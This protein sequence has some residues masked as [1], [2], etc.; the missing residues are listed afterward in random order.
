MSILDN[1]GDN[2]DKQH[3]NHNFLPQKI[4]LEDIDLGVKNFF[5]GRNITM[6]DQTGRQRLVPVI[7]LNQELFAQR[8]NYWE[9][10]VN[11]N[12]EEIK[13][14]F[15]A[16]GRKG[17]KQGTA[18]NKRTIP[19]MKKFGFTR[20]RTFD[21][22]LMGYD[23]Y[24]VRQ[25]TWVDCDYEIR[26][27][28][29]Y[30]VDVNVFYQELLRDGFS[31]GQGY[32]SINGHQIRSVLGGPTEQNQASNID[33]ERV[34]QI[35]APL[36]VHGKLFDPADHEKKT[37]INKVV[38]K[39]C[40]DGSENQ[41]VTKTFGG[42]S[43][44]KPFRNSCDPVNIYTHNNFLLSSVGAGQSYIVS[45]STVLSASGGTL[46]ILAP[47]ELY[48]VPAGE[49]VDAVVSNSDDSFVA[50][51]GSGG[52][53]E[54]ADVDIY[55]DGG[56]V[57]S[58]PYSGTMNAVFNCASADVTITNTN[59]GLLADVGVPSGDDYEFEVPDS[60][61]EIR[62]SDE[63][64][65]TG[66]TV[67]ATENPTYVIPDI[68]VTNEGGESAVFSYSG[69]VSTNFSGAT[70]T[71]EIYYQRPLQVTQTV[72]YADGDSQW[73]LENGSYAYTGATGSTFTI[74]QLDYAATES[75][76]RG[77]YYGS[78]GDG[79]DPIAPT[80]LVG[81]NAFGNKYRF[82]DSIGN[83]SDG[84]DNNEWRHVDFKGHSFTGAENNYIIDHITGLGYYI[85]EIADGAVLHMKSNLSTGQS[86][87]DWMDFLHNDMGTIAGFDDF[88][89]LTLAEGE[90]TF[91]GA[92]AL[93]SLDWASRF[94][95]T[96]VSPLEDLY[97]FCSDSTSS[98]V[99][100]GFRQPSTLGKNVSFVK[101]YTGNHPAYP[102]VRIYVVRN[103]Y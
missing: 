74:P 34:F 93:G 30:M 33:D 65:L 60:T 39:M 101:T 86:W 78:D 24:L 84:T 3:E 12:G 18:P 61:V 81:N 35:T 26:L 38:V 48:T 88:R 82:T 21:G 4:E 57:D 103:H 62:N 79:S 27:V 11:E 68:T 37:T 14:P 20:P 17:I 1:I 64:L 77:T 44:A 56:L 97:I 29:S 58:L 19:W 67:P 42:Q 55:V 98:T 71:S 80:M 63:F 47:G 49:F 5:E 23:K 73:H 7:W 53:L 40:E 52:V 96:T 9:G 72:S 94:V 41:G 45:A 13:R 8:K 25:A 36:V 54:L 6:M 83:P 16:I 76:I 2:L 99:S 43:S 69:N 95:K 70:P 59:K 32:M 15:I 102:D 92:N 28:T 87:A 85:D 89:A 75:D 91:F 22:T 50:S 100:E 31:D 46:A 51:L 10:L 90:Q 66:L